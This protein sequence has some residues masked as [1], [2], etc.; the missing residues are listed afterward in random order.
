MLKTICLSQN[1]KENGKHLE[2][3]SDFGYHGNHKIYLSGE[4]LFLIFTKQL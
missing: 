2:W 4:I 3:N 1:R